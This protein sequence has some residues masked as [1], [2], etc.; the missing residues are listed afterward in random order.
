MTYELTKHGPVKH[1]MGRPLMTA[2]DDTNP[3]WGVFK[4]AIVSAGGTLSK[5]EILAST[6]DARYMR[7]GNSYFWYLEETV[8]VSGR[9]IYESVI[10]TLSSFKE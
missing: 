3:W 5:P 4:K 7:V 10:R 8:C 1:H 6:T 2:T 9:K